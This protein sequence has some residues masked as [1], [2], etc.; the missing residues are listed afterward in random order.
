MMVVYKGKVVFEY[1]D[2]AR[3]TSVASVRKSVLDMLYAA[4]LKNL[5]DNLNYATVVELGLQ[6]KVPFVH[7]EELANFEQLLASRS[8]IYIAN[9]NGDQDALTPKRGSE[10]PGTHFFYNN[11]DFNALGT[12]FEKLTHK[13]IY[14]A[15]RDDLAIPIGMQDFDRARQKKAVDPAQ[16]HDGYPMWLSTRDMA[17]L[18]VLMISHGNWGGKQL[19]DGDFLSWS[20]N[21]VTPFADINPTSL[22]QIGL[23]TRWG[24]GRL[25][26]VWDGAVYPGN[27]FVGPYQGAYSAM[28]SGGQFI[29]VF[30]MMDLVVVHKVDIDANYAANM[31][32]LGYDSALDMV[33]DARCG[34]DCN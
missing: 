27:T 13:D 3:A 22:H 6:D 12:A 11:W 10:Y 2:V 26:W 18:G 7:P 5:K 14:D 8:G 29:T 30:P 31:S 1:G 23:P 4:E 16:A 34:T 24:Y 28:G 25:W 32:A 19:A 21:V 15:L 17:R 9:G 33:L 20:T